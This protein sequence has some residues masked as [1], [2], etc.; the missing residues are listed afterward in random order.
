[1]IDTTQ[2]RQSKTIQQQTG[3]TFYLATRLLPRR[4]RRVTYVLYAFFRIADEI[5]DDPGDASPARQRAQLEHLRAAAL[6]KRESDSP[7]VTA[8]ADL[9]KEHGIAAADVNTFIDAMATDIT[10][11]RYDTH[12]ELEAYM[13]GSAAAVGRMMTTVML[14]DDPSQALP[15]ATALGEAFQLTNFLRDVREDVLEYGRIYLPRSTLESHGVTTEQIER[16]EF[17]DGFA[18]AMQSELQRTEALYRRGVGGIVLLP[19]ETQ[20]AV[21]L[22]AV[23]YADHHRL[24]REHSYDVLSD[25]PALSITRRIE[26]LVR[27]WWQWRRTNDPRAT[28][29]TVSA[30][31]T[32]DTNGDTKCETSSAANS[33]AR[34]QWTAPVKRFV[35]AVRSRISLLCLEMIRRMT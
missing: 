12:A 11:C 20:F 5:V 17:T 1:M 8:F 16:L 6:G 2:V 28:F 18:A 15:H 23:L 31:I 26:L 9:R 34:E 19:E 10:K 13:D 27:T 32:S 21:L 25:Q 33:D 30:L 29:E 7:V 24:I 4:I 3:T 35:N 14:P 22:A